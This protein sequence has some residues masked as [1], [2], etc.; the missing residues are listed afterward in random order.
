M[1][2]LVVAISALIAVSCGG[3]SEQPSAS[4]T[5]ETSPSSNWTITDIQETGI[6]GVSPELIQDSNGEFLLLATNTSNKRA[7]K[8]QDGINFSQIDMN[9]PIGSDYSLIQKS[10]GTWLLYF[11]G[12]NMQNVNPNNQNQPNMPAQPGNPPQP[13][14][15]GQPNQPEGMQPVEPAAQMNSQVG[16]KIVYVSTS[17][18][19]ITFTDPV[20]TGIFQPGQTRAWGVPDTYFTPEGKIQMM[21]VDQIEGERFEVLKTADSNDGITFTENEGYIIKDGY[22]DPY[23]LQV[24]KDNWILILSTTPDPSRLPQ[25]LYMATSTDG[26]D[27]NIDK[28]PILFDEKINYLD[29]AAVKIG[30][31]QWR[32]IITT[33]EKDKAMTGPY[34]YL[35]SVLTKN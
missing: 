13:P 26:K 5:S 35:S 23:M 33:V 27:W 2:K 24:E 1:K 3:T 10:D 32:L 21:W 15:P 12:M 8:S 9:V 4:N 28:E 7:H 29:P 14:Q 17:K 19:L 30:E 34:K 22:V 16:G 20:E 11:V 25:R 6:E 18:D 31:N